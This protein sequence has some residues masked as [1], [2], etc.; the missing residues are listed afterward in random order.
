MKF[1]IVVFPGTWSDRDTHHAVSGVLRQDAEYIWHGDEKLDQF[2][3]IVLPG[4]FSYGDFLRCGAIARFSPVME[5]VTAFA[6]RGGPVIGICNGFQVLCESGLLPG[7]L[8]RNDHLEFRCIWTDL[9]VENSSTIFTSA[10]IEGQT[11]HIPMSHGE[12]NY[13]ADADT[14]KRLEDNGQVVFRY[15]DTNGNV[16]PDI[17]PNG[18]INN[19]AGIVN[20]HGNVLGMMPHPEK[21][22]EKLIGGDDGNVIF[23]SIIDNFVQAVV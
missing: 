6:E 15:A 23:T 20:E 3:A 10:S 22:C 9:R 5:A 2:D 12:G 1:G 7:V 8:M 11:L 14:I 19:I 21:A 4:G 17:N 13:Q 16:T 18:S